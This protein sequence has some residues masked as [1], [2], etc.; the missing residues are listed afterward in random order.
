M[1]RVGAEVRAAMEAGVEVEG[2]CWYPIA[3]HPGWDDDRHCP[4]GL[5]GYLGEGDERPVDEPLAAEMAR[6][7]RLFERVRREESVGV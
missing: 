2:V 6:Q 7:A 3:N 5:L 4:N 1:A